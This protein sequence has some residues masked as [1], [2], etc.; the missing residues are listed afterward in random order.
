MQLVDLPGLPEKG[1]VSDYLETHTPAE[2]FQE[3]GRTD[4][5]YTVQSPDAAV[6]I[7]D[8]KL[9]GIGESFPPPACRIIWKTAC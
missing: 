9:V 4:M 8:S 5:D 1:D 7:G 6:P 2:L 3:C